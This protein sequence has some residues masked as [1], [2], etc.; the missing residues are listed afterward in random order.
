VL[1][2]YTTQIAPIADFSGLE[3]EKNI[4]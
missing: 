2:D 3:K 4:D 1:Q